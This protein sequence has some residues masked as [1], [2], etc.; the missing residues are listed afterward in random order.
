MAGN[1]VEEWVKSLPKVELHVHLE[2][3]MPQAT[4]D[5]VAARH[6]VEARDATFTDYESFIQTWIW[7]MDNVLL[8]AGD[9]ETITHETLVSLATDSNVVYAEVF[10]SPGTSVKEGKFGLADA[11]DAVLAG[12][13]KARE[14]TGIQAEFIVDLERL[15]GPEWGN[16]LLDTLED[17]VGK[18]VIGIGLGGPESAIDADAYT[19]PFA[20]A[21][22]MGLHVT[23]HAGESKGADEVA[24]CIR[25]LGIE[26]VGHGVRILEDPAVLATVV[27]NKI[28][29]EICPTSNVATGLYGSLEEHPLKTL[30]ESGVV[31]TLNSDDPLF[32]N[33]SLH[34]ECMGVMTAL[35]LSKEDLVG[36]LA[37]GIESSWASQE[38]KSQLLGDLHAAA[39]LGQPQQ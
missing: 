22:E 23:A 32:F 12:A 17:Y 33:T 10:I 11:L 34:A 29:L 30:M 16:T 13:A 14:E 39:G 7:M 8:D 4:L 27:D 1:N 38:L 24:D 20:R 35:G 18:G 2:G 36:L 3:A 9:Y 21:R 25:A 26:R 15:T 31:C 37:A 5:K 6:G 28:P 19:G